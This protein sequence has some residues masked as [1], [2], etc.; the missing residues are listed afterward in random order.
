MKDPHTLSFRLTFQWAGQ[1]LRMHAPYSVV[2]LTILSR[3]RRI[4]RKAGH[5]FS[6]RTTIETLSSIPEARVLYYEGSRR[7]A[8]ATVLRTL[9]G[10]QKACFDARGLERQ[11]A[12]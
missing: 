11:R 5:E 4:Q 9:D 6:T 2:A 12:A 1:K 3:S 7:P 10:R 8:S